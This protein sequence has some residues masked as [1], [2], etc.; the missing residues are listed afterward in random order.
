MRR[1]DARALRMLSSQRLLL[2][3]LSF[4]RYTTLHSCHGR[5]FRV[6]TKNIVLQIPL[7]L[8]PKACEYLPAGQ[9]EPGLLVCD[10]PE[11]VDTALSFQEVAVCEAASL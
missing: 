10:L 4:P 2:S 1:T 3:R 11:D 8:S 5:C 7:I 9:A 6:Y